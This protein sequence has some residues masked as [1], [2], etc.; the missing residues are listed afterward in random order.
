MISF[1]YHKFYRNGNFKYYFR[2]F[3][4]FLASKGSSLR[5]YLNMHGAIISFRLYVALLGKE[6]GKE[7]KLCRTICFVGY[8]I[9]YVFRRFHHRKN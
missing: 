9:Q 6:Q 2:F 8:M 5:T 1:R 3:D 4:V 7:L